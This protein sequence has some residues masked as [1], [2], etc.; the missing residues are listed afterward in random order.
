MMLERN[1]FRWRDT[2]RNKCG[3]VLN[4]LDKLPGEPR[5]RAVE[6]PSRYYRLAGKS[7]F[8]ISTLILKWQ[9]QLFV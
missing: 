8:G 1:D 6:P 2:K 7:E 5:C 9:R 4:T 3:K